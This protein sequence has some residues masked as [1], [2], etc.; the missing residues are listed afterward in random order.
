MSSTGKQPLLDYKEHLKLQTYKL[1]MLY[2]NTITLLLYK[3][4]RCLN[5]LSLRFKKRLK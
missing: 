3:F 5:T 4:I 2:P 1:L